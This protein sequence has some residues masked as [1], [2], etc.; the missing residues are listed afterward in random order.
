MLKKQIVTKRQIAIEKLV[1]AHAVEDQPAL[2]D[3]LKK[4]YNI[5]TNQAA[6][7]RDIRKLGIYKRVRGEVMVY[8]MPTVDTVT[9]ILHYAVQ[10][11]QYNEAM[12]VIKTVSGTAD[13]VGDFID[14]QNDLGVLGTIAGENTVFVLPITIKNIDQFFKHICQRL[15]IK[16]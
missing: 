10:S 2:I 5:S 11:C 7:S 16:E 14:A 8:E 1:K 9:E 12:I 4:E 13:L 15:K 3:L 6:I